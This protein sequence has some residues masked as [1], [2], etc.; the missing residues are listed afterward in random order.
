MNAREERE[1]ILT[2]NPKE[3]RRLADKMEKRYKD[4]SIGDSCFV[5]ILSYKDPK[6]VLNLDQEYFHNLEENSAQGNSEFKSIHDHRIK[7]NERFN[8]VNLEKIFI[9]TFREIYS[10]HLRAFLESKVTG[11]KIELTDDVKRACATI[12]QWLGTPVGQGF[13]NDV[14]SKSVVA[15]KVEVKV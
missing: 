9:E 3:L 4:L 7:D 1:I 15:S 13:L 12:I 5:N 11:E 6:V 2:M 8:E 14:K 10:E